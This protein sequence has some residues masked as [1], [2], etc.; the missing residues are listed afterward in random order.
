MYF[1]KDADWLPPPLNH[2]DPPG[3]TPAEII[4]LLNITTKTIQEEITTW[5]L[6][7]N[8]KNMYMGEKAQIFIKNH[9]KCVS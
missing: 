7:I 3:W 6:Q 2:P 1:S 4:F 9:Y 5:H 8:V